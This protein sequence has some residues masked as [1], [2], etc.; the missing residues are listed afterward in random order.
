MPR[1]G[2]SLL[3]RAWKQDPLLLSLLPVCRDWESAQLELKWIREHVE[4]KTNKFGNQQLHRL[5]KKRGRGYPL[6]YILGSEYFGDL[7][8]RCKPGVLIPRYDNL[9]NAIEL[10]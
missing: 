5:C 10:R 7:S 6:Q 1:L 4:K 2:R 8:I 9:Y 3:A